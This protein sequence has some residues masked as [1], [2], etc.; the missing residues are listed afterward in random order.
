[1][2]S[3]TI[4]PRRPRPCRYRHLTKLTT[5]SIGRARKAAVRSMPHLPVGVPE[6]REP[7]LLVPAEVPTTSMAGGN[8]QSKGTSSEIWVRSGRNANGPVARTDDTVART[9]CRAGS[10]STPAG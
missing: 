6:D 10:A 1:M 8:V 7:D 2:V 4:P 3:E 9:V 5:S